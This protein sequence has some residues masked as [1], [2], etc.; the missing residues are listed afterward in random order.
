MHGLQMLGLIVMI[1]CGE[2]EY[3][4]KGTSLLT[5]FLSAKQPYLVSY[6]KDFVKWLL[7]GPL[8]KEWHDTW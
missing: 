1:V 5:L 3:S 6:Y 8:V 2:G 4:I 7:V